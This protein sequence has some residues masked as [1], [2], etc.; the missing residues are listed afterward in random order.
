MVYQQLIEAL[1]AQIVTVSRPGISDP[2][3]LIL[4]ITVINKY[5]RR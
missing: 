5:L 2:N 1:I 3:D 4:R